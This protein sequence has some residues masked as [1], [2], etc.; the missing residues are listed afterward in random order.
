MVIEHDTLGILVVASSNCVLNDVLQVYFR[1]IVFDT[2][3]CPSFNMVLESSL[4]FCCG[5][6]LRFG[7]LDEYL[8]IDVGRD[9]LVRAGH[10][11][12]L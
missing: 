7:P 6:L 12:F 5:K 10:S 9:L 11:F 1:G 3:C 4:G 2:Q 8:I